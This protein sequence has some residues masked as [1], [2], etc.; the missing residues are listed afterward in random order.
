MFTLNSSAQQRFHSTIGVESYLG[1][2]FVNYDILS[3]YSGQSFRFNTLY[4]INNKLSIG[5]VTGLF[6]HTRKDKY[7]RSN[8]AYVPLQLSLSFLNKKEKFGLSLSLGLPLNQ[9][10]K[11]SYIGSEGFWYKQIA[12]KPTF[13][14]EYQTA[15]YVSQ[16][17]MRERIYMINN[18]RLRFAL[19]S[20]NKV[21]LITGLQ[22][23]WYSFY[24]YGGGSIG[25][26][27]NL[28]YK[29]EHLINLSLGLEYHFN[30]KTKQ[31]KIVE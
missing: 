25:N 24:T 28:I 6:Y 19:D 22:H 15:Y 1:E 9:I 14:S 16:T 29:N 12:T 3:Q 23:Y 4:S 13:Y 30:W 20:F 18:L 17:L 2:Y 8:Y 10:K 21:Y 26:N 5:I 31:K 11:D 7:A 27:P